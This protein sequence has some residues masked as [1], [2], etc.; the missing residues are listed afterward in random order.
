MLVTRLEMFPVECV[1]RGYLA[2]SGWRDY[3]ETGATSGYDLPAGLREADPLPETIF[4]P[5]SKAT[6]GHD[7]N[8]SVRTVENLLGKETADQL[9]DAS[10]AIYHHCA[11]RCAE[12]GIILADTKLEFGRDADGQI[13]L[14]DEVVTPDSSRFWPQD[15]WSPGSSPPSFD[16]QYV[17][18]HLDAIGWNHTPPAPALDPGVVAGTRTRYIEAY[19]RITQNPFSAYMEAAAE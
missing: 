14:A 12:A 15:Q 3:L 16:K 19:E 18:D 4:T 9:R 11:Q 2:G 6:D 1:V 5:A 10:L 7:E 8:I 17:R 13:V